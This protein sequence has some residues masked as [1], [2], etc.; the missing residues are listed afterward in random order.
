MNVRLAY[1]EHGLDV[2]LPDG[3]VVLEPGRTAGIDDP[4]RAVAEAIARPIGSP[5]L[6]ELARADDTVA[7]VV[8]DITR[9]VPN[10]ILLPPVL[11]TLHE[12]GI[13]R[14]HVSIVIGT[15]MHG[16]ATPDEVD[17][18]LGRAIASSYEVVC[19]DARDR[20]SMALLT[21]TAR[22]VDVWMNRRYLEADVRIVT[23]FIEPHLF[24]GYSGGGK[25]VMP[26]VAGVEIVMSNHG[27]EML[28]H[29][30]ATWCITGG[31]PIFEEQRDIALLTKP[32]FLLNVTLNE[33]REITGVFAGELAA[34]HDAGI[35]QAERQ[36]V[37]AV[38]HAFDI[39]VSTNMGYPADL[40]L[41]QSV[42]GM[43]VAAQAVRPGGDIILVAECRDGVGMAE[44]TGL[45]MSPD[46]S[47]P[48]ALLDRIRAPGFA[49]FDQWQ[50]QVQAMVQAKANVWLHSSLSR[51]ATEAAHLR[52]SEDVASTIAELRA[53]HVRERGGEPSVL[54]LPYGQLTVPRLAE[55]TLREA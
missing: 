20:Q 40:N 18:I 11:A 42:K 7:I 21:T 14:E 10:D 52:Y 47:G 54:A 33:R 45:L 28:S 17:R 23:G 38:P 53:R 36:Y 55:E 27:A 25:G 1:G 22:G 44:Y 51:E 2:E 49:C 50:V 30:N 12:A 46:L 16:V 32:L 48:A 31:N 13:P 26:G 37:R 6:R 39:V 34:A 35:A 43:S 9:P 5:P 19:H 3:A 29:P 41:Y 15:G 8:S 4:A 24:A